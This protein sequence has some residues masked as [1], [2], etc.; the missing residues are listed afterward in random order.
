MRP[1]TP[2]ILSL[3]TFVALSACETVD[4]AGQDIESLGQNIS[5]EARETEA[6]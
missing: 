3:L 2:V 5:E 1:I 4:G 6:E